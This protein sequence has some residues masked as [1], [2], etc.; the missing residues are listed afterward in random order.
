[1]ILSDGP[2]PDFGFDPPDIV[3]TLASS[4]EKERQSTIAG[5]TPVRRASREGRVDDSSTRRR[6]VGAAV[7]TT[8]PTTMECLLFELVMTCPT[9]GALLTLR[10]ITRAS[11]NHLPPT[12]VYIF[13]PASRLVSAMDAHQLVSRFCLF[14]ALKPMLQSPRSFH[15]RLQEATCA[16]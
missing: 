7:T 14:I 4:P 9:P 5:A 2:L 8:T 16:A 10:M 11:T 15:G 6:S 12:F 13:R 1:M 3:T